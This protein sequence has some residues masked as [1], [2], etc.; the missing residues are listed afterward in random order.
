MRAL[1]PGEAAIAWAVFGAAL[2]PAP[3]RL[4]LEKWAMWQP[5]NVT[6][7]PDGHI[8]FH[9]NGDRWS[10]DFAA[11][12]PARQHLLVHELVHVWQ[13]QQGVR[14]PLRR[15]PFCRYAYAPLSPGRPFADYGIEQQAEIV[16]DAWLAFLG[17]PRLGRPPF[18][19]LAALVPF[20]NAGRAPLP[21]WR[22]PETV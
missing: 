8:W 6:M 11:E 1:T 18:E 2:D 21:G 22:Q 17:A 3:V 4:R 14:L 12:P 19:L 10:P 13:H 15:H 9:P 20:W 7:S 16:A 5:A